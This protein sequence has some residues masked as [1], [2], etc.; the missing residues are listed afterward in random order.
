MGANGL[1]LLDENGGSEAMAGV[2]YKG[3]YFLVPARKKPPTVYAQ[4]IFE[5]KN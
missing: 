2:M 5:V 1:L 3:K 4:A